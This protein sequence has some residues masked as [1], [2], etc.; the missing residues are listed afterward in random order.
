MRERSISNELL[1]SAGRSDRTLEPG[2]DVAASFP[3]MA[4]SAE[5]MASPADASTSASMA[6]SLTSDDD[7]VVLSH[8]VSTSAAQSGMILTVLTVS[9]LA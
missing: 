9:L 3:A 4:S 7:G 1:V 6:S 5:A 2:S 8:A